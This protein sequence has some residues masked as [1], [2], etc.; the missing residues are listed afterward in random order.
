MATY[1]LLGIAALAIVVLLFWGA[2]RHDRTDETER[3]NRARELTSAWSSEPVRE[4]A[5][6]R[7][8]RRGLRAGRDSDSSAA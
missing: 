7:K 4:P 3:F 2:N 5:P 8:P 6:V 1:A